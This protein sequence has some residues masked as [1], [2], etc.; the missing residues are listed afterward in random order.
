M[1][2][3]AADLLGEVAQFLA[4]LLRDGSRE[5]EPQTAQRPPLARTP[6]AEHVLQKL[7]D[8]Q[9]RHGCPPRRCCRT[10]DIIALNFNEQ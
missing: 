2:S 4:V 10:N 7:R 3:I 9:H 8:V 5:L 1:R 6:Q